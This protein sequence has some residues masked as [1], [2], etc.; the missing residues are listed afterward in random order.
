M[1]GRQELGEVL[2]LPFVFIPHGAEEPA[3]WRAAH[4][5]A[6]SLP[7]WL[8]LPGG[9]TSRP[10]QAPMARQ[11]ASADV[12]RRAPAPEAKARALPRSMPLLDRSGAPVVGGRGKPVMFPDD[13]PPE[14]FVAQGRRLRHYPPEAL[15]TLQALDLAK[16]GQGAPWDAQRRDGL[17]VDEWIDYATIAIGLYAAA[18]G[19]S[20]DWIL[21]IQDKYASYR[22]NFGRAARDPVHR[23]LRQENVINTRLGYDLYR[24]GN[25]GSSE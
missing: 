8:V 24:A 20:E 1:S 6:I 3:W 22:S 4:P 17:F 5:D 14:L 10:R 19:M 25:F 11:L 23:H 12:P 9:A 13:L 15:L 21:R 16:F 18:A 7:A 2:H